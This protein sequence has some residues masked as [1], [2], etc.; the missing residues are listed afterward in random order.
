MNSQLKI[1]QFAR[2]NWF[3]ISDLKIN[4]GSHPYVAFTL[5]ETETDTMAT[6]PIG[7]SVQYEN[8]Q[9]YKPFLSV[10]VSVSVSVSAPL[11]VGD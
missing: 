3:K 6:V 4:V 11:L 7:V 9:S 5:I 2:Q 1:S 10:S 8:T